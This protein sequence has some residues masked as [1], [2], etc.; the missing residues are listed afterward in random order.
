MSIGINIL[1][2]I[3]NLATKQVQDLYPD[4]QL[5]FIP[6]EPGQFHEIVETSEHEIASH[7]A[8]KVAQA[9]LEKNHNRDFSSFLG[10]AVHRD[11]K[12]LGLASRESV[13]ALFNINTGAFDSA[14][15]ARH[16][17][18]HLIWHTIDLMEVRRKPEYAMKFRAGPIIPKR[19]PMNF[20]RLNLQ[21]DAFSSVMCA[22]LGEE[23][24][25]DTLARKRAMG[26]I[27]PVHARRAEDYP[28]VIAVEGAKYA[29]EAIQELKPQRSKFMFF[30]RQLAVEIGYTFDDNSIRNWW[31]FSEPAQDMAWRNFSPETILGCAT[32][33]SDDPF[34]R[35]TGHLVS[36][37]A[38]I[39]PLPSMKLGNVYN[40]YMKSQQN[41]LLHRE[42]AEKTFA[43]AVARGMKEESG[44]PLVLAANEQ[45]ESLVEGNILGWCA[46]AL[47]AAARAFDNALS[48]GTSP[49]QAARMQFEGTK[50]IP[51]WDNL[52][53]VGDSV[54]SQKRTGLAV[55]MGSIAEICNS[56]PVFAPML[57]S[58]RFTMQDPGYIQKLEASNDLAMRPAAP[59]PA[60]PAPSAPAPKAPAPT[61]PA[62]AGPAFAPGG[63]SMGG[64][65]SS[66]HMARQRALLE[67][68]QREQMEGQGDG[69]DR[70]Q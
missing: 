36:D 29:C 43:D 55:T 31:G 17:V 68:L 9:I 28:F 52:K 67:K 44:R 40:A 18:Y 41:H 6:H 8:G 47:Q 59:A 21:A 39:V 38:N 45:N 34:V 26:A 23:D 63:P 10:M 37:I 66:Q 19:S 14:R 15:E 42:I 54:V 58:I 33:T 24:A 5:M 49:M 11:V 20:A 13:L 61:A 1:Q 35:A 4:L 7:P 51:E 32:S 22:L 2:D 57:N 56:D 25:I 46:N 53:Q 16:M 64:G 27:L 65:A 30:A 70:A 69:E 60:A 3:C 48:S 62:Y 50:D 12:W